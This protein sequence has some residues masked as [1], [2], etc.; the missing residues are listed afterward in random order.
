MPHRLARR[1]ARAG[2]VFFFF[3][4]EDGIRDIGVTGVQTCALPIS[5]L[6]VRHDLGRALA[7]CASGRELMAA[8]FAR[9]VEIAAACDV[10]DVVPV[11]RGEAFVH[12]GRS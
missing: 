6:A 2:R 11:L 3:Q 10:S 7:D 4:A 9:D 12:A 1:T 8:G 5:Y